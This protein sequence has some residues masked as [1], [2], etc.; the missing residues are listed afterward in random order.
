MILNRFA[1]RK[2]QLVVLECLLRIAVPEIGNS[3]VIKNDILPFVIS[4]GP[5]QAKGLHIISPRLLLVSQDDID[6]TNM[7]QA[8]SFIKAITRGMQDSLSLIQVI[9]RFLR[10]SQ[11]N[12]E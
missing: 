4:C 8:N 7:V 11:G 9:E 12:V 6:R 5:F 3:H 2:R 10:L 1:Y